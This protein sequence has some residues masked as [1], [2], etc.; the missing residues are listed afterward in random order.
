MRISSNYYE[1]FLFSTFPWVLF[2]GLLFYQFKKTDLFVL[3]ISLII[4]SIIFFIIDK[5][6][7]WRTTLSKFTISNNQL[8]ING[9]Q[10]DTREIDAIEHYKTS[11]PHSLLV[12]EFYLKDHSKINFMD[13]PK[14]IFYKSN[15]KL[16]SKS[17]DI[18]FSTFPILKDKLRE[19]HY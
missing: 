13:R 18:L 10:I 2:G 19:Q 14:T 17:L 6:P 4:I 1:R 11:P 3:L 7:L 15:N 5:I 8:F 9:K 12:F 16:R